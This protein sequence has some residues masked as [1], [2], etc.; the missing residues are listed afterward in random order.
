VEFISHSLDR[1]WEANCRRAASA[2]SQE[3]VGR[4]GADNFPGGIAILTAADY[5]S[6]GNRGHAFTVV[7]P[8]VAAC[9]PGYAG[10][11]REHLLA[12]KLGHWDG[13]VR[14]LASVALARLLLS[15][16]MLGCGHCPARAALHSAVG[17]NGKYSRNSFSFL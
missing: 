5:F 10:A 6:L 15:A 8:A 9:A 1:G 3:N 16:R 12:H 13:E 7:A 2:A 11:L 4:Q 14:A 17:G